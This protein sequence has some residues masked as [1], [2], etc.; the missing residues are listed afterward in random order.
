MVMQIIIVHASENYLISN[1]WFH[2]FQTIHIRYKTNTCK[3]LFMNCNMTQYMQ[4]L[5]FYEKPKSLVLAKSL[6]EQ[7]LWFLF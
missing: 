4:L 6:I 5:T 2:Y 3:R 7:R 1:N